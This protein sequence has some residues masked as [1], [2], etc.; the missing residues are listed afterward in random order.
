MN[1]NPKDPTD[2]NGDLNNDS[3]VNI[4]DIVSLVNIILAT[5]ESILDTENDSDMNGDSIIDILDVV[6]LTDTILDDD[7]IF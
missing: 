2:R 1:L 3:T 5:S 7:A 6:K 4:L